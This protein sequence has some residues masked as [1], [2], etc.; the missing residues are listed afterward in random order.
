MLQAR[1][2]KSELQLSMLFQCRIYMYIPS[3]VEV[4]LYVVQEATASRTPTVG[5]FVSLGAF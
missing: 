5:H 1:R 3:Y 2:R 4:P